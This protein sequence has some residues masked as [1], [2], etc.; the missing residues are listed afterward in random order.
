MQVLVVQNKVYKNIES[1]IKHIETLI[2]QR[3][4]SKFDVLVLPEMFICPYQTDLF[5]EYAQK[6]NS[7][8]HLFLKRIAMN[9]HSYIIGGSIPE[10]SS[11]LLYNTSYIYNPQGEIIFK[12]RKIHLFSIVYP[13]NTSFNEAASL[14]SGDKIGVFSTEF[15]KM[16]IMICFDIRYPLLAD[17]LT[18]AGVQAIFVPGA[19]NDFTG[20]LHWQTT[21]KARAIDN[22]L[23]MIGCSP[24]TDSYGTYKTY[25]HS[26]IVDPLGKVIKELDKSPGIIEYNLD[27]SQVTEVRQKLPILKNKVDLTKLN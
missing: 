4:I 23:F 25:G 11:G 1:T 2:S 22:Q 27:L 10:D 16:G 8:V 14:S 18:S 3:K 6:E 24:S 19:F 13:D 26:I 17:K 12:Y 20:P 21:F 7:I 15:G 9:Y 5:A